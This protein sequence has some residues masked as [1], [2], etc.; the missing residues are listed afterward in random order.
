MKAVKNMRGHN[1]FGGTLWG[2]CVAAIFRNGQLIDIL[3]D[4]LPNAPAPGAIFYARPGRSMKSR[5]GMFF[6][7]P[8][9]QK[10]YV[11]QANAID[12][13]T[14]YLIQ[15]SSYSEAGKAPSATLHLCLK[16][17]YTL[18]TPSRPGINIARS[19]TNQKRRE[20]LKNHAKHGLKDLKDKHGLIVRSA[21]NVASLADIRDDIAILCERFSHICAQIKTLG[22]HSL[23]VEILPAPRAEEQAWCDWDDFS[24]SS[25]QIISK[26]MLED[27]VLRLFKPNHLLPCGGE[28]F[29]EPTRAFVSIDVNTKGD[30]SPAACLKANL[31]AVR[32]LPRLLRLKGLGG[33]VVIDFAPLA[34]KERRQVTNMLQK[35]LNDDPVQT[36]YVGWT[37][38]GNLELQRARTRLA[39]TDIYRNLNI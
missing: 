23:P 1:F 25:R 38:I 20:E 7:L 16:G 35:A 21:A 24:K 9:G 32:A 26:D 8:H 30:T 10:A 13:N 18:L 5:G 37:T 28:I 3:F 33:V 31:D 34:H 15:I 19:I 17:R 39:L 22:M 29:I 2:H 27:A 4:P 11:R 36:A 6:P 14:P 12:K